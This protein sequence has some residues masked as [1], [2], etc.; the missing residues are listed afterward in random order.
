MA[1]AP[2]AISRPRVGGGRLFIVVGLLMALFAFLGVLLVGGLAGGGAV[3]GGGSQV[4]V[5][6][7]A[8]PIPFRTGQ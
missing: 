3:G 6:V 8:Q 5:I 1:S 2:V 7:A 4:Q